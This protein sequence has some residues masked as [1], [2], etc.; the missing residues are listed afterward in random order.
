MSG[1]NWIG[2]N[3][4][5]AKSAYV[6][7]GEGFDKAWDSILTLNPPTYTDD[8]FLKDIKKYNGIEFNIK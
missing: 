2:G 6:I 7:I 4:N 3:A 1:D 5:S 8:Q